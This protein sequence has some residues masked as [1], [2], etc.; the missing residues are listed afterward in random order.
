LIV[1][2]IVTVLDSSELT[3][4]TDWHLAVGFIIIIIIVAVIG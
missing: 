1:A 2:V 4:R 3:G